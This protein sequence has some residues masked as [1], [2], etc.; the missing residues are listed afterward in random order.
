MLINI[1]ISVKVSDD[2]DGGGIEGMDGVSRIRI[3]GRLETCLDSHISG[4]NDSISIP[5]EDGS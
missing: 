5:V 4:V 2:G 3:V 1:T